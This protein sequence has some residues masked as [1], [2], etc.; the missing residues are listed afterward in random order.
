MTS[1]RTGFGFDVHR[2]DETRD[3]ILGG[4]NI[5]HTKGLAGHS[6]AD[7]LVHAL[8]DALLGA[9]ALGDI[10]ILFPDSDIKYKGISSMLLLS[11][12]MARLEEN[13]YRISNV[14]MTLVLQEPKISPHREK[15]INSISEALNI[16]T[17]QVSLKASTTEGLGFEGRGE[18]ITAYANVLVY[19][20]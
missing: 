6:D 12:V 5:P 16:N 13:D 9:T 17:S 3:L 1:F 7:V 4:I 2:F 8:I 19:S 10:G 14:D 11:D 18:G 15:I 20:I